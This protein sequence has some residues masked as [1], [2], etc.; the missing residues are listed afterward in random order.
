MTAFDKYR[1]DVLFEKLL[2]QGLPAIVVRALIFI[3]EEQAGWVKL[4]GKRSSEFQLT[5]GTRQGS[6]LSPI[7]FSVCLDNL[8]R[9]LRG[10]D[11]SCW[12]GAM[13][14]ADDIT[15]T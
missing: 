10:K 15:T 9:E 3:Y 1:Y 12:L 14:Y 6:V 8:L 4:A 2:S 13:G 11:L 7:L 5:N